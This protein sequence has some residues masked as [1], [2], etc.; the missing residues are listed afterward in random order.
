M[1]FSGDNKTIFIGIP[2]L[3]GAPYLAQALDSI[4]QQTY[5]H[6][7]A[8]VSD[9]SSTDES[10]AI[11]KRF[12]SE[13][14]RLRVVRQGKELA[15]KDNFAYLLEKADTEYF[16]WLASD[17]F[18]SPEFLKNLVGALNENPRAGLAF[19]PYA[20]CDKDGRI[21]SNGH[22]L[23][24]DSRIGL[25]R[26]AKFLIPD[27]QHRDAIFYGLYRRKSIESTEVWKQEGNEGRP[28]AYAVLTRVL[29]GSEYLFV[30]GNQ[31][32]WF[33]RV[34]NQSFARARPPEP[35]WLEARVQAALREA[36]ALT[37]RTK[38]PLVSAV[39][40]VFAWLEIRRNFLRV[41][42]LELRSKHWKNVVEHL[43]KHPERPRLL[44]GMM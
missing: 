30:D 16:C 37:R 36:Q 8:V 7:V 25:L 33:N 17:D 34:H 35:G 21:A 27:G 23:R 1:S 9:N 6:W 5:P 11:A 43:R 13:D 40:R 29:L 20:E 2:V 32:L 42:G 41:M 14:S 22:R 19:G 10:Y 44:G 28:M 38:L 18:W 4:R 26:L 12:S 15:S 39:L 24:Y 31:F 3:N